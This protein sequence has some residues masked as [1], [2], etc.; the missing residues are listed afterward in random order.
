MKKLS[1]CASRDRSHMAFPSALGLRCLA[2]LA[3]P[4]LTWSTP[5]WAALDSYWISQ[6]FSNA[7][8]SVQYIQLYEWKGK[9]TRKASRIPMAT[10]GHWNRR[11]IMF[12]EF[13]FW[14]TA[15]L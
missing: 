3:A 5:S 13:L 7:D 9:P 1:P 11:G 4:T 10:I 14:T 8:G 15:N 12:E 6:H 2:P